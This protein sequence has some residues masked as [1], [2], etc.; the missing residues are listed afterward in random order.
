MAK[1]QSDIASLNQAIILARTQTGNVLGEIT[2]SFGTAASCV[3]EADGT[4]LA[5]LSHTT[6]WC[7]RDY[8]NALNLISIASG[9]N[10]RNLVDPYGRPYFIDENENENSWNVCNKDTIG[11]FRQP[12]LTGW[13]RMTGTAVDVVNS[14]PSC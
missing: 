1:M 13:V 6:D 3:F 4:D 7:W 14:L 10:V 11:A 2:G 9:V 12:F 5:T 8:A